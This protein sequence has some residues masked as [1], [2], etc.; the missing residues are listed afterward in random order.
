MSTFTVRKFKKL[1]KELDQDAVSLF[2]STIKGAD[3]FESLLEEA[4]LFT[5]SNE[6]LFKAFVLSMWRKEDV[7][8]YHIDM[9]E[10]WKKAL[11]I[12]STSQATSVDLLSRKIF[13]RLLEEPN[14]TAI[15]KQCVLYMEIYE[16][17]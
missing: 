4:V 10:S 5:P 8:L 9:M 1:L 14:F 17:E 16:S 12:T 15:C 7:N 11:N 2:L 13:K 3:N 6:T